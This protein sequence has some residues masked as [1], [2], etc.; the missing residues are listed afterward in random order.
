MTVM[1]RYILMVLKIWRIIKLLILQWRIKICLHALSSNSLS[2][3]RDRNKSFSRRQG[4]ITCYS[5][6]YRY[7]YES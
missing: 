1:T 5:L 4:L 3:G 6:S 7:F 2:I